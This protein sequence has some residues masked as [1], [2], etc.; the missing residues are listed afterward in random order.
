[1][2]PYQ[3]PNQNV[4]RPAETP[5]VKS[6]PS[7]PQEATVH[8]Y[9]HPIRTARP[10]ARPTTEELLSG[11]LETLDHHSEQLDEVLRRLERDNSDTI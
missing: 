2:K 1:M 10:P 7:S 5:A 3:K 11:V 6:P 4:R 9:V 8:R